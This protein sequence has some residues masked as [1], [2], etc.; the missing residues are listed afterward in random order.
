MFKSD[1]LTVVVGVVVVVV[2]V[3]CK[4]RSV[5]VDYFLLGFSTHFYTNMHQCRWLSV[6]RYNLPVFFCYDFAYAHRTASSFICPGTPQIPIVKVMSRKWC[7][8][9]EIELAPRRNESS[10][11]SLRV[12]FVDEKSACYV[13]YVRYVKELAARSYTSSQIE[14][15]QFRL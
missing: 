12:Y 13:A 3:V 7:S 9:A 2:G 10:E 14:S 11:D 1:S 8:I 5:R 6:K 15:R 4:Y